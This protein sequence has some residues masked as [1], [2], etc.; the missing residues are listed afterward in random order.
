MCQPLFT[1]YEDA[2]YPFLIE[3][4]PTPVP[5]EALGQLKNPITSAGI[6]TATFR[7]VA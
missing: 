4:E 2:W 7:L 1:P 6:E 5:L 3:A